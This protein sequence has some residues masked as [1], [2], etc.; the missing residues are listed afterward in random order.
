MSKE[1]FKVFQKVF[2][3]STMH[4]LYLLAS[5]GY[6]NLLVGPVSAGKEAT[7]YSAKLGEKYVALKIYKITT[8]GFDTMW[9]Y[10]KGD[11][12]F[13]NVKMGKRSI[14][15]A[16]A[17]KEYSNLL[18]MQR[19]GVRVPKPIT[20]LNNVLVMEFIGKKGVSA[21]LAKNKPPENPKI[22]FNKIIKYIELMYKKENLIHGDISEYN[23]MNFNEELVVIDVSQAVLTK[24]PLAEKLLANDIKNTIN[25]FKKLGVKADFDEIYKRIKS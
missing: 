18:K 15:L 25:W 22:W 11:P 2:D 10:L 14:I 20:V 16:W 4:T 7:V 17:K 24:H 8:S 5:R 23:I 21:P 12:R 13:T 19:C 9:R 3:E 1:K 6:F